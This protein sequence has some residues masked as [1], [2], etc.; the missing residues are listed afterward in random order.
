MK[1]HSNPRFPQRSQHLKGARDSHSPVPAFLSQLAAENAAEIEALR[2]N[3]QQRETEGSAS[4]SGDIRP[5]VHRIGG[6]VRSA[7][8]HCHRFRGVTGEAIPAPGGHIHEL[9]TNT[10]CRESHSHRIRIKTGPPIQTGGRKDGGHVHLIEGRTAA[11]APLGEE[12]GLP[13]LLAGVA[14]VAD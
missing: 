14:E 13:A 8:S 9:R 2:Q 10:A 3:R 12:T 6:H 4:L 5:H 11:G 1:I 7:G